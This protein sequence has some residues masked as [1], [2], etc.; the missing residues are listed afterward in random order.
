MKNKTGSRFKRGRKRGEVV[1]CGVER[2]CEFGFWIYNDSVEEKDNPG[3]K[4]S[5]CSRHRR[6]NSYIGLD[7]YRMVEI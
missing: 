2:D 1:Y 4:L 5:N 6:W 7:F 3:C